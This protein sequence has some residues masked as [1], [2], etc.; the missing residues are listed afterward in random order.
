MAWSPDGN[1]LAAGDDAAAFLWNA[2]T[3][4]RLHAL[5][6]SATGMLAFTPDGRTLVSA[7]SDCSRGDRHA[8]TRWDVPSGT[9]QAT[10]GLPTSGSNAAFHLSRDGRTVYA[11]QHNSPLGCVGVYDAETGKEVFPHE[12]HGAVVLSVAFSPDGRTLASGSADRTVRLWDLAG[13]RPQEPRPPARILEGHADQVWSVAFSP[14]GKVLASGAN[15][16]LICAWNVASGRRLHELTGHSSAP[17]HLAYKREP[18]VP[19]RRAGN[20][21]TVKSLGTP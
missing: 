10:L 3:Y 20:H 8:F 11:T 2:N 18:A 9:L 4:E 16:G 13:W 1:L 19:L 14:D 21:G 7:R 6:A 12:G 5:K 17:S 15:D